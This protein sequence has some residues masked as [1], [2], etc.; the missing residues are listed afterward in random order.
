[1]LFNSFEFIFLFMPATL[2]FYYALTSNHYYKES[3][4]W[5]MVAS[6][7]FYGWW[8]PKYLLL[9]S[10]SMLINYV[11]AR[12]ISQVESLRLKKGLLL[13]GLVFNIGLL[14]YYKYAD[15]FI[16]N[17]ND[18]LHTDFNLLHIILPLGISFYTFQQIAF[19]VDSYKGLVKE[20][21]F[22][23]YGAFV[24]FFPHIISGPISH[25]KDIMPQMLDRTR[26][27]LRWDHIAKGIFVFNM[28]LAKKIIIADTF[29]KIANNG[30]ANFQVLDVAESWITSFAYTVQL[31]FDFSGYSDMAIGLGLLFNIQLPINFN[32][33][34]RAESIQQFYRRWHI[35]LSSFMRDYIYIPLGGNKKGELR[36]N[37]NLFLTF[38]IGGLWHGA[39]WTFVIWGAMNGI[40]MVVNRLYQKTNMG[41]NR[42]LAVGITFLFVMLVRIFFRA[43]D[44][45]TAVEI[46]QTMFGLNKPEGRFSLISS[47]YDAPIWLAGMFLLFMPNSNEM[48]ARFKLNIRYA[49]AVSLMVIVN[50]IFLNSVAKQDFLY[51]DF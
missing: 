26:A 9:I 18:V 3:K 37:V 41:M 31:Y 7:N 47:F 42:I 16:G 13:I 45:H 39:N 17:F 33:P 30:Y 2:L 46:L 36:T 4:M 24:T 22:I 50:M 12:R 49:S 34:H 44:F 5:L 25:H 51:F 8:N 15:F 48:T 35:S 14:V 11:I 38:L 10:A 21:D 32:S 27:A 40:A 19:L 20:Y 43:G 6:L 23:Y 28:G 29:G 1:M